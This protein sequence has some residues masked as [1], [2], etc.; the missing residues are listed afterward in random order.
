MEASMNQ[1]PAPENMREQFART[2]KQYRRH[3]GIT[4]EELAGRSGLHRSYVADIERGARNLSLSS[5][6]KLAGALEVSVS[7]LFT[8]AWDAGNEPRKPASEQKDDG[9]VEILLVE[10]NPDDVE[11]TLHA[12]R[13]ARLNNLV[14]VVHDGVAAL[15]FLSRRSDDAA[16]TA[17][18]VV[19]LDLGLP[20]VDGITVLRA[21]KG[22]PRTR[23]IPV[24]VLTVSQHRR[25][26]EECRQLG[27]EFYIS[28]PVDFHNFSSLTPHFSLNWT[29]T[30]TT[31]GTSSTAAG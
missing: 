16:D 23:H 25:D 18:L 6:E 4:Q 5:I 17:N 14:R 31:S 11:L 19:L 2:L 24:I 13:R 27:A 26:I 3:L 20:R 30:R 12:F 21:I 9:L 29:L 15:E 28:K 1:S 22:D 7:A 8:S 10:D